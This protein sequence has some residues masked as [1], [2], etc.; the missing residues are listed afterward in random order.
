M[1]VEEDLRQK[2]GQQLSRRYLRELR[3]RAIIDYR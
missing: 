3:S 1:E 2:E